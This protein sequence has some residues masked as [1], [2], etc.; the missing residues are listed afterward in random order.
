MRYSA[1]NEFT[2][3]VGLGPYG[4]ASLTNLWAVRIHLTPKNNLKFRHALLG[5][6]VI[7]AT[8]VWWEKRLIIYKWCSFVR[9]LA[10]IESFGN[11]LALTRSY[12]ISR[13]FWFWF[14]LRNKFPRI[15][16]LSRWWLLTAETDIETYFRLQI[17]IS[18]TITKRR[19]KSL[20]QDTKIRFF[21][22]NELANALPNIVGFLRVLRFSLTR[23]VDSMV[24]Q[25]SKVFVNR[26]FQIWTKFW[27]KKNEIWRAFQ[28]E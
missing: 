27:A 3:C 1:R 5:G 21:N 18:V 7:Y 6:G 11:L 15:D 25:L 13:I 9:S 12:S 14:F 28:N 23:N 22:W 17:K 20:K 16:T 4:N 19:D 10:S 24:V 8:Q 26:W 2:G